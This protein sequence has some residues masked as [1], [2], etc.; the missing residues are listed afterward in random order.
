ME[1][2]K[3]LCTRYGAKFLCSTRNRPGSSRA[4]PSEKSLTH[5]E[6]AAG[7]CLEALQSSP[8]AESPSKKERFPI[9]AFS[10]VD[11]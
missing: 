2:P 1:V 8:V 9:E 4:S 10:C 11:W 3:A 7:A 5:P 6:A